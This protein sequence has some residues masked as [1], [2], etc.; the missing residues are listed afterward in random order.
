MRPEYDAVV[1]GA[2]PGGI[3]AAT[4]AAEAGMSV[5]LVDGNPAPG[6][7]IW[8]GLRMETAHSAPHGRAFAAWTARLRAS[9]CTV[10][11]GWQVVS[12]PFPGVLRLEKAEES[13]DLRYE[14]LIVAT[15]ARERFL[16]FPGW[17]LPGVMGAGGLQALL[18]AGLRA[19]GKR[20]VVAGTGPLLLAAAA[21][22]AQAGAHVAGIYEQAP[23]SRLAGFALSALFSAS[24]KLAEG[25]HCRFVTRGSAYRFGSW[26]TR[27]EGKDR[28]EQ[29]TVSDGARTHTIPCDWL[30]CGFH[31]VPNLELPRLL[32]CAI[33]DGFVVVDG[34]QQ[35]SVP[36]VA[37]VGEL[38]GIGG[39]DKALLEG[40]IAGWA[41]AGRPTEA[42]RMSRARR[43]ALLFARR[44]ERAFALRAELR[45]L[46][47]PATL[48]CR[49]EDVTHEALQQCA[50]R[51][52]ARLHARC[53]MGACQGRVCGSAAEFLYG[54]QPAG[55][56]PPVFPARVETLAAEAPR[57]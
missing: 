46:P 20:V 54:W 22:A 9:R 2:G 36:G 28:V 41:A 35:S 14:R 42:R 11:S 55:S 32:G 8:R 12:A 19:E 33:E 10:L 16:P 45:S 37:C 23:L 52:E 24:G 29:V 57:P 40:Q 30:A 5:C 6:G 18:K 3:A 39:M 13:R 26:V 49:C 38:T 43:G 27:A 47:E 34:A 17:T 25:A 31:L 56:R 4:A 48:I 44:L 21:G 1:V 50:S 7:Q 53:G 51:R 15:G